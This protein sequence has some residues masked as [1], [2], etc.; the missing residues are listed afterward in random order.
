M[1]LCLT[2]DTWHYIRQ[3]TKT[4]LVEPEY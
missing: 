3:L 2:V 1:S 4:V